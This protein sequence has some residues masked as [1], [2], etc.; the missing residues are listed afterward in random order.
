MPSF[1]SWFSLSSFT[2]LS[3]FDFCVLTNHFDLGFLLVGILQPSKIV[4]SG[5]R[6]LWPSYGWGGVRCLGRDGRIAPRMG[7]RWQPAKKQCSRTGTS[8][9]NRFLFIYATIISTL[10]LFRQPLFRAR[11]WSVLSLRENQRTHHEQRRGVCVQP[12][13][14]LISPSVE[15]RGNVPVR[16][17]HNSQ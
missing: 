6:P 13:R 1:W 2:T 9:A 10:L 12:I 11:S 3:N 17:H 5:S 7:Q 16:I 8:L 4:R 14:M 15:R